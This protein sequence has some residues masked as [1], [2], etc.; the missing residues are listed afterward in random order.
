MLTLYI[1]GAV[2][3]LLFYAFGQGQKLYED[4]LYRNPTA[5]KTVVKTSVTI[6]IIIYILLWFIFMPFFIITNSFK[7]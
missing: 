4:M 1:I 7:K 3:T 6:S 2:L 5:D